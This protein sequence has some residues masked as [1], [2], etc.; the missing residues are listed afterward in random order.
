M[1][2]FLKLS[3]LSLGLFFVSQIRL[4]PAQ[5][6]APV[7]MPTT[8]RV[9]CPVSGGTILTPSF[10]A[11][12][13]NGH[14]GSNY[15]YSC[16][17]GSNGRRAKAIDIPTTP[18][19]DVMLPTI[20]G[21]N[22]TWRLAETLC[23][24][25]GSYPNCTDSNGGTGGLIT[26][27]GTD[28]AKPNDK[29]Y[30]QF[31]HL[32]VSTILVEKDKSYPP[33]TIVGKTDISAHVHTTIGKNL[34]V[35]GDSISGS[36]DCDANWMPSDFMCDPSKQ[37]TNVPQAQPAGGFASGEIKSNYA[38]T[39]VG[40]PKEEMPAVCKNQ[41]SPQFGEAGNFTYY[42][43]GD[44]RWD[45][46]P[47]CSVGQVGCGATSAAMITTYFGQ[48]LTPADVFGTFLDTGALTCGDGIYPDRV[49][50]WFK[51]NGYEVGPSVV[52]GGLMDA[53]AAKTY[54]DKG[55]LI[56][57]SSHAFKG[58]S[59]ARFSHVFVVQNVD[60][61]TDTFIMRDPE[62]CA[63][64]PGT[65]MSQNNVQ[66]IKSDK[67]PSWAYAYPIKKGGN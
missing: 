5:A 27:V 60:P 1:N 63:Y 32:K 37:P 65:E 24:G 16:T 48:A 62:N 39:K 36:A 45:K 6:Q 29:W 50:A 26:F 56:L 21:E 22:I 4:V 25:S 61:Q 18:D 11:D 10:Q 47:A 66:P 54:I 19:T 14:C 9:S 43:Q 30:I 20:E 58:Q 34:N 59:G 7:A 67:I 35:N 12:S 52:A 33:G 17:C 49:I 28:P 2:T 15:G 3:L 44:S 23:A 55:Y 31:L 51:S 53:T 42:C 38:C 40:T 64:G 8:L 46:F 13:V 41:T 57:G